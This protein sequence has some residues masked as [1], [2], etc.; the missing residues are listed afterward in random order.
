MLEDSIFIL[1]YK[2]RPQNHFT[3]MLLL[4]Q[5]PEAVEAVH[6]AETFGS[7]QAQGWHEEQRQAE[8]HRGQ[9]ARDET[10]EV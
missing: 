7:E 9:A 1:V 10:S 2:A 4:L 6:E 8:R 5:V 3:I